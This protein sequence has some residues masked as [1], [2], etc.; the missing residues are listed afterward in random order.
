VTSDEHGKQRS[1]PEQVADAVLYVPLG[2]ALEARRLYPELAARGRRQLLF[3]RTV[4]KYAVKRGQN[5][6]DD[7]V[8]TGVAMVSAFLPINGSEEA[9]DD[10]PVVETAARLAAVEDLPEVPGPDAD[11]LAIPDYDS[12]SAFQVMPRLEALDRGDL[13]AVREYEESTRGRRTIL[14]KIAQLS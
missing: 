9:A 14:N 5:R 1:A 3:T 6:L 8:A 4:G 11:H 7:L 12:L 13:D 10:E 2:L